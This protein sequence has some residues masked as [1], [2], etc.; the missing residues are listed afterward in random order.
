MRPERLREEAQKLRN[1]VVAAELIGALRESRIRTILLKG[2]SVSRW[3]YEKNESRPYRDID[4]L[5]SPAA[6]KSA[7]NVVRSQGFSRRA[8]G[9]TRIG[10]ESH[11]AC[12]YRPDDGVSVELHRG[13]GGVQASDERF[14]DE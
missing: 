5:V 13:F 12:W 10:R 3:L 9:S 1:D 8:L 14:W 11:H 4:L 6:H 7:E 2:P